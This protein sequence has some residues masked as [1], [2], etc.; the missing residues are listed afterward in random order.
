[1]TR[2]ITGAV[3]ELNEL[4]NSGANDVALTLSVG[5]MPSITRLV[6]IAEPAS[7]MVTGP[8]DY[9]LAKS[10]VTI[11]KRIVERMGLDNPIGL[12][13]AHLFGLSK[14]SQGKT[15]RARRRLAS[16]AWLGRDTA[17]SFLRRDQSK[18]LAI[19]LSDLLAYEDRYVKT[20]ARNRLE[21]GE[22]VVDALAVDWID[23]FDYY[24]RIYSS[25]DGVSNDL[26]V[27]Y[28]KRGRNLSDRRLTEYERASLFHF[29]N[30]HLALDIFVQEKG[31][32][33][34][35][36]DE[37]LAR[38]LT[39]WVWS[40]HFHPPFSQTDLDWLSLSVTHRPAPNSVKFLEVIDASDHGQLLLR[41]W[42]QWLHAC[43]CDPTAPDLETCEPHRVIKYCDRYVD[44]IDK[45]WAKIGSW[46]TRE[47][48][49]INTVRQ[50]LLE[51]HARYARLSLTEEYDEG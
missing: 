13:T 27:F 50:R 24:Y 33:W 42:H 20:R 25:F 41:R 21:A 12:A 31:G 34:I 39:D 36:S 23:R 17:D 26:T 32:N 46:F 19:F 14:Q 37:D 11:T 44:T 7:K 15:P 40:I 1:L 29:A 6:C 5:K 48:D 35:L 9:K 18:L 45:E 4:V 22:P 8:E 49:E 28:D 16:I 30:S 51:R 47:P 3:H 2:D 43:E 10:V 38:S